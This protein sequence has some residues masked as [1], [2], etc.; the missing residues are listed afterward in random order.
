MRSEKRKMN[1]K[2]IGLITFECCEGCKNIIL[3]SKDFLKCFE[4]AN[5]SFIDENSKV[6][7]YENTD[8]FA[9][10]G[11]PKK[12]YQK[13][14]LGLISK[15]KK[16]IIVGTCAMSHA[17]KSEDNNF[18]N[19]MKEKMIETSLTGCPIEFDDF[20]EALKNANSK[21]RFGQTN[22]SVCYECTMNSNECFLEK[23]EICLGPATIGGCNSVCINNS[24]AC[25][26]CRT[27]V[28]DHKKEEVIEMINSDKS[29][30]DANDMSDFFNK[31]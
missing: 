8:I 5:M 26:G 13:K 24:S 14:M 28:R 19:F 4:Q 15:N 3:Q 12:D 11:V 23:G 20:L 30:K 29:K 17:K 16:I 6:K 21:K 7:E 25:L 9:I 27:H 10:I 2:K 18:E 31:E 22:K 1:K